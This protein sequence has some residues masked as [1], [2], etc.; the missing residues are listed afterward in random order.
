MDIIRRIT[1]KYLIND[2]V[3]KIKVFSRKFN[4]ANS[5][6]FDTWFFFPYECVHDDRFDVYFLQQNMKLFSIFCSELS[7]TGEPSWWNF[8]LQCR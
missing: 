3:Q 2:L 6:H 1:S 7:V 5:M 4:S 8:F